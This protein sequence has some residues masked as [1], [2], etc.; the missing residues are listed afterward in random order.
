ML[1]NIFIIIIIIILIIMFFSSINNFSG[2]LTQLHARGPEDQYL[3]V[4]SEKYYMPYFWREYKWNN[5]VNVYYL[6]YIS[7]ERIF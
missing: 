2:A 3:M 4:N 5:P 6:P 7:K 1:S